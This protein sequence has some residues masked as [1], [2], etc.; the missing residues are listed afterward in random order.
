MT[1]VITLPR[2]GTRVSE[3]LYDHAGEQVRCRPPLRSGYDQCL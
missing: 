2:T 1:V 3:W